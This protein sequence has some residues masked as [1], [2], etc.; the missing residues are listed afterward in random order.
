MS[1]V[2]RLQ[3]LERESAELIEEIDRNSQR[4]VRDLAGPHFAKMMESQEY[5]YQRIEDPDPRIR[6]AAIIVAKRRWPELSF[7]QRCEKII[8]QDT[9]LHVRQEALGAVGSFYRCAKEPRVG[10]F[11]ASLILNEQ[12]HE[13]LRVAAYFSLISIHGESPYDLLPDADNMSY[14]LRIVQWAFVREYLLH[15]DDAEEERH[16]GLG[17]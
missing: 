12:E 6:R 3:R 10:S 4:L 9:D 5:T 16:D 15:S 1:S 14:T 13:E 8:I 11:L 2:D 7:A 17:T